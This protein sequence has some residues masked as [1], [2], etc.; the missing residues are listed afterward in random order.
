[1]LIDHQ[2]LSLSDRRSLA[3]L[4]DS[5]QM[6]AEDRESLYPAV[7]RAAA[8]VGVVVRCVQGID[9]NGLHRTNLEALGTALA[10]VAAPGTT[11]L[12]DGFRLP[13]CPVEHRAV[14]DGD[15]TSAAI[16]AASVVAKVTRDRCMRRAHGRYPGWGFDENVGYSTPEHREAILAN[17][18][19]ALH[20]RSFQ[21]IAYSQ[22]E[23]AG[24]L[25][26]L[27]GV[28][29]DLEGVPDVLEVDDSPM[30]EG[31]PDRVEADRAVPG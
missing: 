31:H 12:T 14:V 26:A 28:S 7:L 23:L 2:A 10:R 17:G 6:T 24:S 13:D 11:C 3:G 21:S 4:H 27:E 9:C 25:P 5:K 29:D 19:S 18:I 20:R 16:A 8:R 30:V 22:L 1:M 15:A